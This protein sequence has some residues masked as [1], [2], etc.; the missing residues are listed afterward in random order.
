MNT[1]K[2]VWN[3]SDNY[4]EADEA[5]SR[6]HDFDGG[7]LYTQRQA[8]AV[9]DA[10]EINPAELPCDEDGEPDMNGVLGT[11]TGRYYRTA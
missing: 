9:F 7:K 4:V 2:I 11:E 5:K 6:G 8:F 10:V 1:T 3:G